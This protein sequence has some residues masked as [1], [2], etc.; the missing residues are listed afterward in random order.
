MKQQHTR[1]GKRITRHTRVRARVQGTSERPRLAVFRSLRD[2]YAQVIDD[3]AGKT[4]I[5]A[6]SKTAD[7]KADVGERKGK[8]A[9]AY[10]VGQDIAKK[11][12]AAGITTVVFDRGGFAYHGRVQ[13]VADGA[14][15]GGLQF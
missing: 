1:Q 12:Q 14:R 4:L 2:V 10:C 6:H 11:A 8:T 13:A 5:S 7:T 9:I 15:D 3:N